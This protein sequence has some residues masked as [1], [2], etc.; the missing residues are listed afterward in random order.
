MAQHPLTLGLSVLFLF[1]WTLAS[2]LSNGKFDNGLGIENLIINGLSILL[3]FAAN[4]TRT[5]IGHASRRKLDE[6][7]EHVVSIKN[8]VIKDNP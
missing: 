7:H 4:S 8:T 1:F 2:L 6:I 5:D 3:L